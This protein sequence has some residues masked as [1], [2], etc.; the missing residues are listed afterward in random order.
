MLIYILDDKFQNEYIVDRYKSFIWT[1]RFSS[2]GDF[3]LV[4]TEADAQLSPLYKGRYI[5]ISSSH[6]LMRVDTITLNSNDGENLVT[7]AGLSMESVYRTRSLRKTILPYY[8]WQGTAYGSNSIEY[9]PSTGGTLMRKNLYWNPDFSN[10]VN[11]ADTNS[12]PKYVSYWPSY[13][14]VTSTNSGAQILPQSNAI[15]TY[16][17]LGTTIAFTPGYWYAVTATISINQKLTGTYHTGRGL[18]IVFFY[19]TSSDVYNESIKSEPALNEEG[20]EQKLTLIFKAPTAKNNNS[21]IRLYNGASKDNGTVT[22]KNV[23]VSA[24]ASEAAA[25]ASAEKG[26]FTGDSTYL[27]LNPTV[28]H[29]A[30]A[31]AF[32]DDLLRETCLSNYTVPKDNL[33]F[34]MGYP[35]NVPGYTESKIEG[36]TTEYVAEFGN[37]SVY[38]MLTTMSD[39]LDMGFYVMRDPETGTLYT[40]TYS[41]T[42]RSAY[43]NVVSPIIFSPS[44]GTFDNL[45]KVSSDRNHRTVAAVFGKYDYV[46]V[47]HQGNDVLLGG[48]SGLARKVIPVDASDIDKAKGSSEALL[49]LKQRGRETLAVSQN[50]EVIDG[51]VPNFEIF[52]Y[53]K[54][55]AVGSLITVRDDKGSANT[56]RISEYIFV[57]DEQGERAYPTLSMVDS[58]QAGTWSAVNPNIVWSAA[59]GTWEEQ[60]VDE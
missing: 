16:L 6:R 45:S 1:E 20:T 51:E 43:Q 4:M 30:A 52:E 24:H 25:K 11:N 5:A 39:T 44:L 38:D 9:I 47:D 48:D 56:M 33:P 53:E 49:A 46:V 17:Q 42:D 40:G 41:G 28:V 59:T 23:L 18:R 15:D 21:F 10:R 7:F 8:K 19:L 34:I 57:S 50:V 12:P 32:M 37:V 14:S 22:W 3:E 2:E 54:D 27:E 26:Y 13:A 55:Y 35:P 58:I 36:D 31:N 60:G 29:T